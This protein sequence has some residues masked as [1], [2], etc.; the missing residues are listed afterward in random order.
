MTNLPQFP[1][2]KATLIPVGKFGKFRHIRKTRHF[3]HL[4]KGPLVLSFA[5]TC[6]LLAML[7]NLPHLPN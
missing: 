1:L 5:L 4:Q 2:P 3:C 7:A 6:W